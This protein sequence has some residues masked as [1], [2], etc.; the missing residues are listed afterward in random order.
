MTSYEKQKQLARKRGAKIYEL[1]QDRI[2]LAK[3]LSKQRAE[4]YDLRKLTAELTD[5]LSNIRTRCEDVLAYYH[6]NQATN[7]RYIHKETS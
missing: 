2:H 3:E 5:K 7:L 6:G 4:I 1:N